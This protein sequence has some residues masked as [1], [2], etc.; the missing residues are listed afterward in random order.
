MWENATPQPPQA[1]PARPARKR[2]RS[3]RDLV[4]WAQLLL[5]VGTLAAAAAARWWAL[6]FYPGLRTAYAAVMQLPKWEFLGE[7]RDLMKFAET[8]LSSLQQAAREVA[9]QLQTSLKQEER[10]AHGK[11]QKTV[12]ASSREE[13]YQPGFAM[14]FPLPGKIYT[15]TSAYGWR[16]DPMGG[17]GTDFHTGT[18][19]AVAEGTAVLAAADGV[20][21]F[22]GWHNSYGN[23]IRLL[24]ADGDETIYAHMQYLFVRTGQRVTAGET[25]G[26]VGETGNATGPHLHFELLHKGI[27]YDPTQALQN[28]N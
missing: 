2:K 22:A 8:G 23:Y 18:D 12:P 5:C 28:A 6:P 15:K 19:L 9:A 21:R 25:M 16:T 27:R 4:L 20:V 26:T 11:S 14:I 7:E 1:E 10:T 3:G 24:H 13:S 17:Q